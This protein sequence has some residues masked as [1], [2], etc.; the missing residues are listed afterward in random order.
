MSPKP[1]RRDRDEDY[2]IDLCEALLGTP[3]LRQ[4]RFDWLRGDRNARGASVRLPVDAYWPVH[5]L[6]V[7]FQEIQ[8]RSAVPFFDKPERMTVSGVSRGEQR[9]IYDERRRIEIPR[10]GIALVEIGSD[11]LAMRG[12]RLARDIDADRSTLRRILGAHL[13]DH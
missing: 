3:A 9:R 6:V 13:P 1:A 10:H 7:E 2:A 11:Q 4:H 12:S 8:H 5:R